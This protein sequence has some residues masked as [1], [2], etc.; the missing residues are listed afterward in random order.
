VERALV[1]TG[2]RKRTPRSKSSTPV[3]IALGLPETEELLNLAQEAALVGIFEWHVQTGMLRLS[4]HSLSAYGLTEFDGRYETWVKSIF[5]EDVLRVTNLF[6][7]T[8][9]AQK[10]EL[11][12]E[13]RIVSSKDGDLRW[14][15]ARAIVF[16]DAD[17][18][19]VRMVGVTVDITERKRAMAQLRAFTETL[20]GAVKER[21]RELEIQNE[22]R[23][24]A[25]ELLRQAQK[26]KRSDS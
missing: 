16:Y 14:M 5:R 7:T 11:Q 22:A 10:R 17:G 2:K 25:E 1:K 13:F 24:K 8:F 19:A 23:I 26:M 9:A 18:S 6:E 21:T 20:E 12:A 15:E 4:P 3:D